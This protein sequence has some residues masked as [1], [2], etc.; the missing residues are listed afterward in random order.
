MAELPAV[1]PNGHVYPE[2]R[3]IG[4][5]G[6]I[7]KLIISD[8]SLSNCPVCGERGKVID[9]VY[10]IVEGVTQALGGAEWTRDLLAAVERDASLVVAGE[11]DPDVVLTRYPA[12]RRL[13]TEPW[14]RDQILT[15]LMI[16]AT[17]AGVLTAAR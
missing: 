12:L 3:L 17:I 5:S 14:T 9:V 2:T 6:S 8:T 13:I 16:V 4:G 11:A 10:S 15:F 7:G 1:C